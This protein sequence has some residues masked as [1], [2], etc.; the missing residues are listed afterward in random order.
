VLDTIFR[1]KIYQVYLDWNI[2]SLHARALSPLSLLSSRKFQLLLGKII[3]IVPRLARN[4][5]NQIWILE[6]KFQRNI[7]DHY[8]FLNSLHIHSIE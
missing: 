8:K 6:A 2:I 3:H 4:G 7:F 1:G 5:V